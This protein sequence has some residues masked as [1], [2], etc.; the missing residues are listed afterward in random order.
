MNWFKNNPFISLL[1]GVI[2]SCALVFVLGVAEQEESHNEIFIKDG[3]TLWTLS[4]KY[5]GNT[6]KQDW[7][8]EVM[9]A[10]NLNT[11]MIHS[12]DSLVIPNSLDQYAPDQGVEYAGDSE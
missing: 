10:N 5:R 3:D 1:I 12:G 8:S 7:I 11:Q 9:L 6:P 2:F 4:D